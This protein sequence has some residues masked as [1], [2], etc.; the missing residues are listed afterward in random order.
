MYSVIVGFVNFLEEFESKAG[1]KYL[2]FQVSNSVKQGEYRN[3]NIVVFNQELKTR[4]M[5][6]LQ[7][8]DRVLVRGAVDV[9]L[10]AKEDGT[11]YVNTSMVLEG[12][13]KLGGLK[14]E[15]SSDSEEESDPYVKE[16]PRKVNPYSR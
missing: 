13:E 5:E 14:K 9:R 7:N 1:Q 8:K 2:K 3:Y 10:G 4:V 15:E 11:N 12:F 6:I 16:T